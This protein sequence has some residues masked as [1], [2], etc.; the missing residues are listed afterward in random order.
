MGFP[1]VYGGNYYKPSLNFFLLVYDVSGP[2]GSV[3]TSEAG[4]LTNVG[5]PGEWKGECGVSRKKTIVICSSVTIL[6]L[7]V[8]LL[9]LLGLVASSGL[10]DNILCVELC[11]PTL[12]FLMLAKAQ[13]PMDFKPANGVGRNKR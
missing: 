4:H 3:P 5:N 10:S 12:L 2:F 8:F 6:R 7:P 11:L 13:I 1:R 9:G